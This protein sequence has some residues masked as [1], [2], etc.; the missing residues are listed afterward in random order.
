VS[1]AREVVKILAMVVY[2]PL[3]YRMAGALSDPEYRA[4]VNRSEL[5][6]KLAHEVNKVRQGGY[7]MI[8]PKSGGDRRRWVY[9]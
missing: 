5:L 6:W 2:P 7:W 9:R 3:A 1:V 8:V 4:L